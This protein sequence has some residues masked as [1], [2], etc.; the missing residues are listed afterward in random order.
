MSEKINNKNLRSFN[1]FF[2]A[3]LAAIAILAIACMETNE[4]ED[5]EEHELNVRAY[6]VNTAQENQRIP[7]RGANVQVMDGDQEQAAPLESVTN[8]QGQAAFNI[9]TP[10]I[11]RNYRITA[12]YNNVTQSKS[13]ILLC[14]DTLVVFLFDTTTTPAVDCGNLDGADTLVFIDDRGSTELRQNSPENINRYER[15][16]SFTNSPNNSESITVTIPTVQSPFS[17]QSIFLDNTRQ[18]ISTR[19][20][21][22][23][24]GSSLTLCFSVSTTQA[25]IF[26]QT[27]NIPLACAN[28]QGTYNLTLQ[29]EVVEPECDCEELNDSHLVELPERVAVGSSTEYEEAVLTNTL[30]CAITVSIDDQS[31]MNGFSIVSPNFPVT[32]EPGDALT[33]RVGFSPQNAEQNSG[34]LSLSIIPQGTSQE[35]PYEIIFRGNGCSNSCPQFSDDGFIYLPYGQLYI[36]TLATRNDN[37]VYVSSIDNIL[38]DNISTATDTYWVYNPD[39]ACSDVTIQIIPNYADDYA[40][41][42][43]EV[44]PQTV[45][46]APGE[47]A[48][49]RVTFEAPTLEEFRQIT[50]ARGNT[51]AITDSLFKVTLQFQS[52][53]CRQ[54]VEVNSVVT[55]YPDIS[56]IINLRAYNQRT[57]QKPE[58][59]HEVYYFGNDARSINPMPGGPDDPP[60]FGDIWVD[61]NDNT[62]DPDQN[63]QEPILKLQNTA[64]GMKVW[65]TN[66]SENDFTNVANLVNDFSSDPSYNV[67]Y[68]TNPITNINVGDVIAFQFSTHVYALIYVRRVDNGDENTSSRQSGIEF[69]SVYPIYVP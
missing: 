68:S 5:T 58:A 41:Q 44:S 40:R 6:Q 49:I 60:Q 52:P 65:Q 51:G 50:A 14:Q 20:V 34:L 30:S 13:N 16:W 17:L 32:L 11:G 31:E 67:G 4:P 22:V 59:E 26:E 62:A 46:L 33:L 55:V 12:T 63:P 57:P 37:R 9:E 25:G 66:Y 36:D 28:T 39:S 15:C 19:N 7:I 48:P 8:N 47:E 10:I 23:P 43:Y 3:T 27:L 54:D 21:D 64:I 53:G 38:F 2:G 29:A 18:P 45:T 42:Y 1:F 24:P 56:P 35:C 69:R 61:V